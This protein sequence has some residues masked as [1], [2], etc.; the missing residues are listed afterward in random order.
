MALVRG[1]NRSQE[2]RAKPPGPERLYCTYMSELHLN[3][4]PNSPYAG[5]AA[6]ERKR[7]TARD[8]CVYV[9]LFPIIARIAVSSNELVSRKTIGQ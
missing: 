7:L 4:G 2:T 8:A 5:Q 6:P 1:M 3:L 9:E